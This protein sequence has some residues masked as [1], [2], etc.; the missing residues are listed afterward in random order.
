MIKALCFIIAA[1]TF[2][3]ASS[4]VEADSLSALFKLGRFGRVAEEAG[5]A[6]RA[7]R[8]AHTAHFFENA[9][10]ELRAAA[11]GSQAK[12]FDRALGEVELAILASRAR[13]D[14]PT[15][16]R[17]L[18]IGDNERKQW[19]GGVALTEKLPNIV[20]RAPQIEGA[21]EALRIFT[22]ERLKYQLAKSFD[23]KDMRHLEELFQLPSMTT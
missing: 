2:S 8:A 11:I 10:P 14:L 5:S 18:Q 12:D 1:I 21:A 23:T 22:Y 3:V 4:T 20:V 13:I 19:T 6:A 16:S 9:T 15:F 17:L 7:A